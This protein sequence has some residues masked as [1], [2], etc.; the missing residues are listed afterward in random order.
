V[1]T[2]V[3]LRER[4]GVVHHPDSSSGIAELDHDHGPASHVLRREA[5]QPFV[6]SFGKMVR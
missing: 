4:D 2:E 6:L 5:E 1:D 3:L